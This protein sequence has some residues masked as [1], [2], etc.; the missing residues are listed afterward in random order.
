MTAVL[1]S[2]EQPAAW[3]KAAERIAT[4]AWYPVHALAVWAD[5]TRDS[6]DVSR[7]FAS[8]L[9]LGDRLLAT[10]DG[11]GQLHPA[12]DLAS[13]AVSPRRPAPGGGPF[14]ASPDHTWAVEDVDP[15]EPDYRWRCTCKEWQGGYP[16]ATAADL[17]GERHSLGQVP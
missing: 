3:P 6:G 16:S 14:T 11:H 12:A 5:G 1:W 15:D 2:P 17:G 9:H 7:Q 10:V 13:L 8:T 4:A